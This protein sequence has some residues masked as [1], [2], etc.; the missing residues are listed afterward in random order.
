MLMKIIADKYEIIEKLGEGG[1]GI[2]Y[3]TRHKELE[4]LYGLKL[5]RREYS[6]DE[7][8]LERFK[9]EARI[10][11]QLVHKNS[12]QLRDFGRTEEGELYMAMDYCEGKPLSRVIREEGSLPI[13]RSLDLTVQILDVMEEAHSLGIVHRD[14]K[15]Y[16]IIIQ[17]KSSGEEM[18]KVLD[19]GIAKLKES[20]QSETNLTQ[21]GAI[22]GTPLYMAPEQAEGSPD[23]DGRADLYSLGEILYQMVTGVLPIQAESVSRILLMQMTQYPPRFSELKLSRQIPSEMEELIFKAIQKNREDRFQTAEEFREACQQLREKVLPLKEAPSLESM[24]TGISPKPIEQIGIPTPGQPG[25]FSEI[26]TQIAP[27]TTLEPPKEDKKTILLMVVGALAILGLLAIL[28]PLLFPSSS[29]PNSRDLT[30]S[31][32]TKINPRPSP[33]KPAPPKEK[34]ISFPGF[35]FIREQQYTCG[36]LSHKVKEFRHLGTGMEFVLLPAGSFLMG[37]P[38]GEKMSKDTERPQHKVM[39]RSFLISKYEVTQGVWKKIMETEPWKGKR[40]IRVGGQYPVNYIS[41]QDAQSFCA[42]TG[43]D[44]PSESEWEYASRAGSK[45]PH[46]WGS[47]DHPLNYIWGWDNSQFRISAQKVGMKQPNAFGLYDTLGNVS[48]YCLD[49]WHPNYKGHPTDGSSW[50]GEDQGKVTRGGRWLDSQNRTRCADRSRIRLE[51][52]GS[53][54]YGFRPVWRVPK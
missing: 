26:Q 46:Y 15:P 13:K 39:V 29:T 33:I 47:Q 34:K 40:N 27:A 9:R 35:Q 54:G 17:Q 18:I 7:N 6:E 12:V 11:T 42:K 31:N 2:V 4:N 52:F 14:M 10:L 19:F 45:G 24:A 38:V 22:V 49:N 20:L 8:L 32:P 3:L 48:E 21:E 16:N 28:F 41:W 50:E 37:S 53:E 36:V 51:F 25:S 23:I 43:L 1:F 44:L 5:I 30:K